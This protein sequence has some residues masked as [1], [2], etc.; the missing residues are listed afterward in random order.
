M[1]LRYR[2]TLISSYIHS[3]F[4]KP[5]IKFELPIMEYLLLLNNPCMAGLISDPHIYIWYFKQLF[6]YRWFIKI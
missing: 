6:K 5:I 4:S 1:A 3:S 2:E